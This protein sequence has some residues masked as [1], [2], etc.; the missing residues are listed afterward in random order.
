MSSLKDNSIPSTLL[1]DIITTP[2]MKVLSILKE[3][4][5]YINMMSKS[6][7]KLIR[8]LDWTIKVITS[9][10]LYTYE[11]EDNELISKYQN[12]NPDFKQFIEFVTDYNEEVI[13]VNKKNNILLSKTVQMKNDLATPSLKIKKQNL[14]TGFTTI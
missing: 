14:V 6:Q 13:E 1:K 4:K 8:E 9:H 2:Y 10:S 12:E 3:T 5:K 7:S 11:F